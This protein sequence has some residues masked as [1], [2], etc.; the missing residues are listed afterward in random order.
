MNISKLLRI[1]ANEILIPMKSRTDLFND[2][3]KIVNNDI[4]NMDLPPTEKDFIH[5]NSFNNNKPGEYSVVQLR[6]K[7]EEDRKNGEDELNKL[8]YGVIEKSKVV[9]EVKI[10]YD[11]IN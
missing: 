6:W 11:N 7:T 1:F 3:K 9:S 2:L 10:K 8:G 5:E 4:A